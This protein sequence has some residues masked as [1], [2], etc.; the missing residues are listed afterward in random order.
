MANKASETGC[1][2]V[3]KASDLPRSEQRPRKIR[4]A[5]ALRQNLGDLLNRAGV[6]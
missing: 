3:V 1:Y 5:P 6:K 4:N 2:G